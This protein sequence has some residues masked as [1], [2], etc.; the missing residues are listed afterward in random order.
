MTH[1]QR[2][3]WFIVFGL[4]VWL[5]SAMAQNPYTVETRPSRGF[6]PSADQLSS[7][8]DTVEPVSGKVHIE[9]PLASLPRGRANSG[10]DLNL[11]YDSHLY[12]VDPELVPNDTGMYGNWGTQ[13]GYNLVGQGTT[14]GWHYNIDNL[15]LVEEVYA[16]TTA[17]YP[18]P[19]DAPRARADRRCPG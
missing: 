8:V 1:F 7:P 11:V 4:M 15:K 16:G 3:V 14:G 2:T 17:E 6:M 12:D 5:P 9:I 18:C 19:A 13:T 10:F